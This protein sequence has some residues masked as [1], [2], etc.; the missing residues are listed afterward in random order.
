MQEQEFQKSLKVNNLPLKQVTTVKFLGV[1]IDDQLT[2]EPHIEHLKVKLISSIIIIKRIKNFI[3]A[4]AYL[5]L[6]NALFK[7]HMTYCI[8]CWGGISKYKL[9][10]L[11]SVQKRCIRLLFRKEVN[12]DHNEYYE[13]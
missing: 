13:T 2:W 7:S 12:Y 4:S 5:Q 8:S 3:P 11:F 9:E 6:Y 10:S 1:I